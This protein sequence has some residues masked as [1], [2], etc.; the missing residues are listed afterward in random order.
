MAGEISDLPAGA[1]VLSWI[2]EGQVDL[3]SHGYERETMPNAPAFGIQYEEPRLELYNGVLRAKLLGTC[4]D[5][6][7]IVLRP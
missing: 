2:K 4:L 6:S 3:W 5:S 1:D 7:G